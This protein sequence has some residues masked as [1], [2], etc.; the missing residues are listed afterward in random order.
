MQ[1]NC[2]ANEVTAA[3]D[4]SKTWVGVQEMSSGRLW[5]LPVS[6][7]YLCLFRVRDSNV[8][9][10]SSLLAVLAFHAVLR[11]KVLCQS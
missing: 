1:P 7:P 5:A 11:I 6:L 9:C 2:K 4:I 10:V 3:C 8:M